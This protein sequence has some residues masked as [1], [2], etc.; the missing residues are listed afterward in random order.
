MFL[1]VATTASLFLIEPTSNSSSELKRRD[2]QS[3]LAGK[4]VEEESTG[5]NIASRELP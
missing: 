2:T 1:N 5:R 3:S 4:V